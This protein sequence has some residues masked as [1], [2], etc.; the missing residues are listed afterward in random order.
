MSGQVEEKKSPKKL[1][2]GGAA[3]FDSLLKQINELRAELVDIKLQNTILQ[4][5]VSYLKRATRDCCELV[6]IDAYE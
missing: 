4:S 1:V 3:H 6:E 5:E 2:R